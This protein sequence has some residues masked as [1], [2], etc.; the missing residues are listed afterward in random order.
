MDSSLLCW[1][2]RERNGERLRWSE[3]VPH[4]RFVKQNLPPAVC[5][6]QD[7]FVMTCSD[8]T[9]THPEV[10]QAHLVFFQIAPFRPSLWSQSW[11]LD[12]ICNKCSYRGIKIKSN[13]TWQHS[14]YDS[15]KSLITLFIYIFKHKLSTIVREVFF[16]F[17]VWANIGP[18]WWSDV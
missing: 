16:L 12:Q 7:V 6:N 3:T 14:F 1:G 8:Y 15:V 9:W 11:S 5:A 13:F 4:A 10:R 18:S 2:I 17:F